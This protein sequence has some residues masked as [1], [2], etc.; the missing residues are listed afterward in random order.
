MKIIKHLHCRVFFL[1]ENVWLCMISF[2]CAP[3]HAKIRRNKETR[4]D[5]GERN[6][7]NNNPIQNRVRIRVRTARCFDQKSPLFS[8]EASSARCGEN[9][10]CSSVCEGPAIGRKR[11][12]SCVGK[13]SADSSVEFK[14]TWRAFIIFVFIMLKHVY[15]L[16]KFQICVYFC[17][18]K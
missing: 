13:K 11:R 17:M 4:N 16:D 12:K 2:A 6:N 10:S 3:S 14:N 8:I 5:R 18:V 7:P 15:H 1:H 9:I